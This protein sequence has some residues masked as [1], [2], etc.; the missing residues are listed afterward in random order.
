MD[1]TE[2]DAVRSLVA[3]LTVKQ[4]QQVAEGF[5]MSYTALDAARWVDA[6][7][8]NLRAVTPVAQWSIRADAEL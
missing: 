7:Q 8:D 6:E 2:D 1:A 5:E 4:A 3:A